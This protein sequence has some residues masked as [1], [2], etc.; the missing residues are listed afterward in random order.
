VRSLVLV[1]LIATLAL[2][3]LMPPAPAQADVSVVVGINFGPPPPLPVYVQPPAP[4][5]SYLWT[6]GYWAWGPAGYYWVPGTWVLAPAPGLLWT[7]GYWAFDDDA[8]VW[9]PGYWAPNVGFYGGVVYGFGYFGVGFVGGYWDGDD[10]RY[11]VAVTNVNRV[12]V[13]DVFFD[14]TVIVNR[15]FNRVCYDGGPHGIQARPTWRDEAVRYFERHDPATVAQVRNQR[16]AAANRNDL[17]LVNHGRPAIAAVDRPLSR[18]NHPGF[19]AI[20]PHDRIAA[21]QQHGSGFSARWQG[22]AHQTAQ[23]LQGSSH[24]QTAHYRGGGSPQQ[25]R[26]RQGGSQAQ[27]TR[28]RQG[29][30]YRQTGQNAYGKPVNNGA[31]QAH[32][33]QSKG[34][35]AQHGHGH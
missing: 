3:L 16:F 26:Y 1:P 7:P 31:R 25:I 10:F 17:A 28:Y 8:Y 6:P 34:G 4:G 9:Y 29:S 33:G 35:S 22:S 2:F 30:A 23:H 20:R 32:A 24:L 12:F 19:A 13:H 5:P 18:S 27:A 15:T 21:R 11:N 14:R